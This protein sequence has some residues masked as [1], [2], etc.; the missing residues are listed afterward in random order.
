MSRMK[1]LAAAFC[2]AGIIVA[3]APAAANASLP[4]P[5][6]TTAMAD[7]AFA[8]F[9][10]PLLVPGGN[11]GCKPSSAHPYPVVLVHG[12]ADDEGSSWVTLAPLLANAG[13][14]VYAL[15]YGETALSLGVD[16]DG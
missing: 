2:A 4:V 8:E 16:I 7:F 14:C 3:A 9:Y 6:G 1:A 11:N 10:T 12:T 15:N 5:Y 13:Y